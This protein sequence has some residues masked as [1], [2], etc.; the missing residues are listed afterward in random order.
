MMLA[1]LIEETMRFARNLVRKRYLLRTIGRGTFVQTDDDGLA[2]GCDLCDAPGVV[3]H[4]G[5]VYC[6]AC[7]ESAGTDFSDHVRVTSAIFDLRR[8]QGLSDSGQPRYDN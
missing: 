5:E 7:S 6:P 2:L 1:G 3:I 4:D 8:M